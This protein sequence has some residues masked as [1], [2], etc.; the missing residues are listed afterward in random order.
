MGK[1]QFVSD[2]R[3]GGSVESCF[4]LA[5]KKL[6]EFKNKPGQFL[7]LTLRDR[8]GEVAAKV[9]DNAPEVA[10]GLRESDLVFVTGKVESYR[11][12]LQLNI[13]AV[14]LAD[15]SQAEVA[16]FMP[17]TSKDVGELKRRVAETVASIT[18]PHI[19]PLLEAFFADT[20][21]MDIYAAA[22]AAKA[23]HHAY[24]GG[25]I[26]HVVEV[27]ELA[28][29]MLRLYPKIDRDLL[30]AGVLLH[31]IGK[32]RELRWSFSI[33]Y[34]DEGRLLGHIVIGSQMVEER[35]QQIPNFPEDLRFRVIHM[36]LSHHGTLE[37]GSP[38]RPKTLEA[39]AL[40]LIED[41]DAQLKGF[42]QTIE[43]VSDPIQAW[44]P[45]DRRFERYLY[46]GRGKLGIAEGESEESSGEG[47]RDSLF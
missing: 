8:T 44:T 18:N 4:V 11:Q 36:I 35:I 41:L 7:S 21:F 38:K 42:V 6:I 1:K 9:W 34:T 10:N 33:D 2:L 32:T 26:E 37:F 3:V 17:V 31:D 20:G 15:V 47:A 46:T 19:K 5:D 16:D 39:Q 25:L 29:P 24:V 43:A 45:F 40:H 22:P 28:E 13:S 23:L 12:A 14:E 30:H 27:I